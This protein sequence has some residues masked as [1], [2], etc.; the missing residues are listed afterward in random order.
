M[1]M[2]LPVGMRQ[3]QQKPGAPTAWYWAI[4]GAF[5]AVAS[6]LAV[7]VSIFWGITATL[8]IGLIGYLLA[9][10]ML[11]RELARGAPCA[12]IND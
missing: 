8:I 4:N 6:V 2:L 10:L 3:A 1:G 7:M 11:Q 5:S 12:L 9:F